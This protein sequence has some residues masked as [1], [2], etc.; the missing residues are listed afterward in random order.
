MVSCSGEVVIH[1]A[2]VVYFSSTKKLIV[3]HEPVKLKT[4]TIG[5][6][7]EIWYVIVIITFYNKIKM[8]GVDSLTFV[9]KILK[10][11]GGG[12]SKIL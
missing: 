10:R 6:T 8:S 12:N 7:G 1:F 4:G 11:E 3:L 9:S 5:C 2:Y